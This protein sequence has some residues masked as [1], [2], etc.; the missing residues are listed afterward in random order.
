MPT[1][2]TVKL[3]S[4]I[5]I[6]RNRIP[7]V[8]RVKKSVRRRQS[9]NRHQRHCAVRP[10]AIAT[11]VE[12]PSHGPGL[13]SFLLFFFF[14]DVTALLFSFRLTFRRRGPL[15]VDEKKCSP[16]TR[17]IGTSTRAQLPRTC[18]TPRTTL[19]ARPDRNA[20]KVTERE[21]RQKE[22][23]KRN[24]DGSRG[25][26]EREREKRERKRKK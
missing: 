10:R 26:R 1:Y 3:K 19:R 23:R 7:T 20:R 17:L 8:L 11:V 14:I 22:N 16:R 2:G 21:Y 9:A 18:V 4:C 12:M 15:V 24:N 5:I 6:L 13:R 25:K